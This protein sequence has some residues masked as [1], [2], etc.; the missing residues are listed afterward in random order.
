MKMIGGNP[1]GTTGL[2]YGSGIYSFSR[3]DTRIAGQAGDIT[4]E[5][6]NLV[7]QDGGMIN[8]TTSGTGSGG[9]IQVFS[10]T[11]SIGGDDS[12]NVHLQPLESQILFQENFPNV[13]VPKTSGIYAESKDTGEFAG[14][15]G[16]LQIQARD[17]SL[18]DGGILTTSSDGAG[19][20]GVVWLEIEMLDLDGGAIIQST[21]NSNDFG[22]SGAVLIA[23]EIQLTEGGSLQFPR[24][25]SRIRIRNGS[26]INTSTF[27]K[28]DAGF[29]LINTEYLEMDQNAYIASNSFSAGEGGDAGGILVAAGID[30]DETGFH[31]NRPVEAVSMSNSSI[32]ASYTEGT[33]ESGIIVLATRNLDMEGSAL[34]DS[35]SWSAADTGG[36]AGGV[37]IGKRVEFTFED[38][39]IVEASDQIRIRGD[40]GVN[41]STA[42]GGEAGIIML[43][44]DRLEMDDSAYIS[45]VSFSEGAGGDGGAVMIGSEVYLNSGGQLSLLP[46][47]SILM[48]DESMIN[49]STLGEG[50]SGAV[51]ISVSDLEIRNDAV[52]GSASLSS[53]LGGD[54]GAVLIGGEITGDWESLAVNSSAES[55][56]ISGG[57]INTS[58]AGDGDAGYIALAALDVRLTDE[59][60]VASGSVNEAFGGDAGNIMI[61]G[62]VSAETGPPQIQTPARRLTVDEGSMISTSSLG[63]GNAGDIDVWTA[64]VHLAGASEIT[65]ESRGPEAG[66]DA[67]TVRIRA[68]AAMTLEEESTISTRAATAGGGQIHVTV[69]ESLHMKDAGITTSVHSGRG[70]GGDINIENPRFLT[71][72]RSRVVADAYAGDGGNIY[73][74]S[75]EFFQSAESVVSAS[76][77]LGIDGLVTVDSPETDLTGD[78]TVLPENFIDAAQWQQTPCGE[79]RQGDVGRFDISGLNAVCPSP[80]AVSESP[81]LIRKS[82]I[83]PSSPGATP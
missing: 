50:A 79:R 33:G 38:P 70:N 65:S 60:T 25:V 40:S 52:I 11:V 22:S 42:G 49:T 8:T 28:V 7:L 19:E 21:T 67:G 78:L 72:N 76:S 26:G 37:M 29:M 83:S 57:S 55:V 62:T 58:S 30:F 80:D 54:A 24:P 56:R 71:M 74:V 34:I 53:G 48:D 20:A 32:I 63:P 81:L 36:E 15:S 47:G 12:G 77:Q 5:T 73:I 18:T 41:S 31:L 45:S 10:E 61:C 66:G 23:G 43:G 51:L 14:D 17:L 35:S 46:A 75:G 59:A 3:G 9:S 1:H 39:A 16:Y 44:V 2:G 68:D 82:G 69:G 13:E 6:K 64:E 4:V 27:G